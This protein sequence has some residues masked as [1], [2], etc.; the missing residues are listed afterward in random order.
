[1]DNDGKLLGIV[2][3]QDALRAVRDERRT[4]GEAV[5]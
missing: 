4:T 2:A 5:S 3:R 1:V